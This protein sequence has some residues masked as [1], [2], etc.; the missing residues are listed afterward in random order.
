MSEPISFV[1]ATGVVAAAAVPLILK[2][3]PPN[4]VYGVRT[5]RTLADRDL[6][7]RANRFA[8][9]AF[10][11]AAAV[12]ASDYFV[13]PELASGRSFRG[14]IVLLAPLASALAL[15]LVRL[16]RLGATDA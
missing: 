8:G 10:L 1:V 2:L 6:W 12:S 14:L 11:V 15:T 16:R 3:V 7:F 13:T 9:W 5:A 4:K